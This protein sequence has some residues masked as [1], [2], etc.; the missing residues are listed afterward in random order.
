LAV[1]DPCTTRGEAQLRDCIRRVIAGCG[2]KIEELPLGGENTECCGFGGLM[3]NANPELSGV[4]TRRRAERSQ[5]DYITYCAMCR[6]NLAAAGKRVIHLLDLFFPH[7]EHPDAALRPRPDWSR[8]QENRARL[9]AR[10]LEQV[11]NEVPDTMNELESIKL[12]ISPEVAARLDRRRI[13]TDDLKQVILHAEASGDRLFNPASGRYKA[14]YAPYKVTFWVEYTPTGDG[15][16]VHNAYAHRME[17][18]GP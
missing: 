2:L 8:R 10:L 14:A 18:I 4:V 16:V 11:W 1:H 15:Y 12:K 5:S 6:D 9:K 3:N 13:L 17:V 7:A